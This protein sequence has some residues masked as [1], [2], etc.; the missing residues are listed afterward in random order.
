MKTRNIKDLPIKNHGDTDAIFIDDVAAIIERGTVTHVILASVQATA[1]NESPAA[2]YRRVMVRL[3]IPTDRRYEIGKQIAAGP[4][5]A[6]G[7]LA[8]ILKMRSLLG[9]GRG[10]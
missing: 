1:D 8:R 10:A 9:K 7:W 3:I 6:E 4:L 5:P 2:M